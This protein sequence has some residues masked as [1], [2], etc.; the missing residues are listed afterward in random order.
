MFKELR[1]NF[2]RFL[3][4]VGGA[5]ILIILTAV[6][7]LSFVMTANKIDRTLNDS[8][9]RVSSGDL[10]IPE[11]EECFYLIIYYNDD[12]SV[13][14]NNE[15]NKINYK[16]YQNNFSDEISN[17]EIF[18]KWFDTLAKKIISNQKDDRN[19]KINDHYFTYDYRKYVDSN[20]PNQKC[21]MFAILDYTSYLSNLHISFVSLLF[22]YCV[23]LVLLSV[24]AVMISNKV[25]EPIQEAFIKQ[26]E[27]IANASHE[28]KTPLTVINTNLSILDD[29]KDQTISSQQKWID[30]ITEQTQRMNNLIIQML[31]LSKTE[32]LLR[33]EET[34]DVNLSK[35]LNKI[36]LELES[37]A[38][39]NKVTL[40]LDVHDDIIFNCN[41]LNIIK[42]MTILLDNAI[43]YSYINTNIEVKLYTKKNSII[44]SV[45]NQGK[46]I[47][48]ENIKKIFQRFYKQDE[49]YK[50]NES[51]KSF[52]LGLAIAKAIID[53]LDGE[54][55]A[56]SVEN[57]YTLFTVK[58]PK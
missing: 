32:K 27:L 28:L 56:E 36:S 12:G 24:A 23:F 15:T 19:F 49:S 47:A 42:V 17:S 58:L 33:S 30:N 21:R 43:K 1:N 22:G 46:G 2:S 54:I 34:E 25:V 37:I 48:K 50:E 52:G 41:Q 31:E 55:Y 14:K 53:N 16:I 7:S 29:N 9:N 26:K 39:E 10:I 35:L 44:Y 20:N 3:I 57:E 13:D 4:V 11:K 40:D 38:F 51:N 8:L 6:Y 45:K 18:V 5:L